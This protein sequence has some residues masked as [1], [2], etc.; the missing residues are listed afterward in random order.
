MNRNRYSFT[1]QYG[2]THVV[3]L[4]ISP[5]LFRGSPV[6][7]WVEALADLFSHGYVSM[8]ELKAILARMGLAT[9]DE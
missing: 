2:V 9:W 7:L 1:D 3:P 5:E 8:D 4:T 6:G